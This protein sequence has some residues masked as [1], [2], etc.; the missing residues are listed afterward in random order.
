MVPEKIL[1]TFKTIFPNITFN[2]KSRISEDIK[3]TFDNAK[4]GYPT[5]ESKE[6]LYYVLRSLENDLRKAK[7]KL[8]KAI[9]LHKLGEKTIEYVQDCEFFVYDL[10]LE[11]QDITLRLGE[12]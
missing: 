1:T 8:S 3:F 5:M 4:S 6:N 2:I 9:Q 10:E 7:A 11:I 12:Q